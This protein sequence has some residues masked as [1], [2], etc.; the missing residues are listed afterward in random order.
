MTQQVL[1]KQSRP[2]DGEACFELVSGAGN[3]GGWV[4]RLSSRIANTVE[5]L[6]VTRIV[7]EAEKNCI[8]DF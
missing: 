7:H 1:I 4:K 2:S 8:L 6:P 5:K 3:G